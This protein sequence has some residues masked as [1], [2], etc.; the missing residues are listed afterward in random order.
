MRSIN[1]KRAYIWLYLIMSPFSRHKK[2]SRIQA[3]S[4]TQQKSAC[5]FFVVLCLRYKDVYIPQNTLCLINTSYIIKIEYFGTAW[6]NYIAHEVI[7]VM[8]SNCIY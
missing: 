6:G 4:C 7:R 2:R 5:L 3:D 1:Y 8:G